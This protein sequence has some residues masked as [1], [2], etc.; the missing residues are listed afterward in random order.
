M[1]LVLNKGEDQLHHPTR[2]LLQVGFGPKKPSYLLIRNALI[3]KSSG[4]SGFHL[5]KFECAFI[6]TAKI[7]LHTDELAPLPENFSAFKGKIPRTDV[8]RPEPLFD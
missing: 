6:T 8:L 4:P 2:S 1:T 7:N 5:N 3:F